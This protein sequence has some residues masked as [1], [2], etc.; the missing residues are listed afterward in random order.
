VIY[1]IYHR[2]VDFYSHVRMV[3]RDEPFDVPRLLELREIRMNGRFTSRFVRCHT[4][5]WVVQGWQTAV[6]V[7]YLIANAVCQ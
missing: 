7:R 1:W 4:T 2:L 5:A 6:N 3:S